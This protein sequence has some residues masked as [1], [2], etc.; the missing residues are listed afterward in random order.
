MEAL[1]EV[2]RL[3]LDRGAPEDPEPGSALEAALEL[4]A[5]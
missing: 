1:N 3:R 2:F 4:L 5:A